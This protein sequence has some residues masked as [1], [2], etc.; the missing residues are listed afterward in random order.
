MI[1]YAET[2]TYFRITNLKKNY[3]KFQNYNMILT[4]KF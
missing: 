3:K 4:Q 1:E 2:E